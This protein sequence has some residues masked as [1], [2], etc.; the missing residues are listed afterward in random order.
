ME[1]STKSIKSKAHHKKKKKLALKEA[2][3]IL[4][5]SIEIDKDALTKKKQDKI[6]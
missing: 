2:E 1:K 6:K 4:D 3:N 5:E